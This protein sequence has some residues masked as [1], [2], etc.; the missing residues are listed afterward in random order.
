M[1]MT[2]SNNPFIYII[3][4][5]GA[6]NLTCPSCP[7]GNSSTSNHPKGL[8]SLEQLEAILIKI[9]QETPSTLTQIY[10]NNWAEPTLHPQ[11]PEMIDLVHQYDMTVHLSSNLNAP[12]N[13]N[14]IVQAKPDSLRISLSGYFPDIYQRTHAGG[15][16]WT[17]ISNIYHL[18]ALMDRFQS[19]FP[20]HLCYHQ[21]LHNMGEDFTKIKALAQD[22][23][24]DFLPIWAYLM[25]VEKLLDYYAGKLT[26][27]DLEVINS[28]A[29]SME[30]WRDISLRAK[31]NYPDCPL[32]SDQLVIDVDGSVSLC[33]AAYDQDQVI[34]DNFLNYAHEELQT[35]KDQHPLCNRCQAQGAYITYSYG[36]MEELNRVGHAHLRQQQPLVSVSRS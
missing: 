27:S 1:M 9:K 28:F 11:L 32:R 24:F 23:H 7:N 3:E 30:T 5:I 20:V 25:P 33:C 26:G 31:A 21:Y 15:D 17:T 4:I 16:S 35:R 12:K 36:D 2:K 29:I 22:C 8:M 6:C 19:T 13:L 18:R 10:L 14:Q 34:A